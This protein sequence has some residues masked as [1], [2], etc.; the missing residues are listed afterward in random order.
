MRDHVAGERG[1]GEQDGQ[2][3]L[4]ICVIYEVMDCPY[5]V[6]RHVLPLIRLEE[7]E[8]SDSSGSSDQS[9][10]PRHG[11]NARLQRH[12]FRL[13]PRTL[14]SPGLPLGPTTLTP[15]ATACPTLHRRPFNS[16]LSV[17]S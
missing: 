5:I 11:Y 8:I 16:V 2:C 1:G 4:A 14:R 3:Q 12:D 13:I 10:G 17:R 7:R 6:G 9:H 15:H